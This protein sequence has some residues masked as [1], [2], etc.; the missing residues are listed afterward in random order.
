[1]ERNQFKKRAILIRIKHP[2]IL[3]EH[4]AKQRKEA[5]R[6]VHRR[7]EEIAKQDCEF[8][9]LME[10]AAKQSTEVQQIN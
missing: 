1:M 4:E 5:E 10:L 9:D 3:L 2:W 6:E 7:R 8:S